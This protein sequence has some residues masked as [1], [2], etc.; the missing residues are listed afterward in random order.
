MSLQTRQ[1][2]ETAPSSCAWLKVVRIIVWRL[3]GSIYLPLSYTGNRNV[4]NNAYVS[5]SLFKFSP[6]TY[7][8][9]VAFTARC[10]RSVNATSYVGNHF[11]S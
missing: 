8:K 2:H 11:E 7:I 1:G 3:W 10:L 4:E 6:D 5:S 9:G